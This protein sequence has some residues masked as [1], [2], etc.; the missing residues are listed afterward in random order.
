ML[1]LVTNDINLG[2][3]F[4]LFEMCFEMTKSTITRY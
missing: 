2:D 3:V 1:V 4:S